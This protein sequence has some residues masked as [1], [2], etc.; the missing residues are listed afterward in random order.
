[1]R[2]S[3]R[4]ATALVAAALTASV[5]FAGD[6]MPAPLQ[7][8]LLAKATTYLRNFGP[9]EGDTAKVMIIFPGTSEGPSR[10]AQALA[11]AVGAIGTFGAFKV[12][13][14]TVP[15]RSTEELRATLVAE[16]PSVV[17]VAEDLN[18]T[19]VLGVIE[20]T[21]NTGILTTSGLSAHVR[22]GIVLGFAIVE[23]H[24][25]LFVHLNQARKRGLDFS[26][27]LLQ[28]AVIVE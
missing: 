5:A 2:A 25:T 6:E 19:G 3:N 23:G 4:W 13:T 8:Q 7:A 26:S 15:F 10:E 12:V 27:K 18:E 28:L 17:Y 16:K 14:A 22:L 1:M 21:R 11:R 20:A 9:S 24:P